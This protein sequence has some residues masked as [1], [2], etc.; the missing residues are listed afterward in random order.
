[1]NKTLKLISVMLILVLF[2]GCKKTEPTVTD[3][4]TE[5][6]TIES[7]PEVVGVIQQITETPSEEPGGTPDEEPER[8]DEDISEEVAIAIIRIDDL[9]FIP[10][11]L[12]ITNGT[13]VIWQHADEYSGREFIKHVLTIYPPSGPGFTSQ[14]MF[15]GDEF[16]ATLTKIG[17]YR[18]MSV[19]YKNRMVGYI[20]VE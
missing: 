3:E 10:K 1:M 4:T 8:P 15:L 9:K 13:T 20:N 17:Q 11:E 5:P 6:Q 2:I 18:Y 7:T 12:N 14:P 19:P 16:N